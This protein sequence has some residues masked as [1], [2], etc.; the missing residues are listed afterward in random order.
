MIAEFS[1]CNWEGNGEQMIC[2]LA[3]PFGLQRDQTSQSYRK[4]TLNIQW[5]DWCWS[6]S[7]NTLATRCKELTHWKRPGC[8]EILR[9]RQR[10]RWLDGITDWMDVSL[11][12]LQELVLDQEAWCAAVHGVGKS[13][14]RLSNWTE[15]IPIRERTLAFTDR[16]CQLP[17]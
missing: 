12:K 4:S 9:V 2:Q 13:W 16:G 11:S 14:T 10:M 7:S 1:V 15:L 6:C 3:F 5:M 17:I 8:W